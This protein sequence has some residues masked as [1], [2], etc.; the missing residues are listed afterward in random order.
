MLKAEANAVTVLDGIM[1]PRKM[2]Y[3]ISEEDAANA[4]K[5]LEGEDAYV[6]EMY[7]KGRKY[8]LYVHSLGYDGERLLLYHESYFS[9]STYK[10]GGEVF[11]ATASPSGVSLD[12]C[13]RLTI[14]APKVND[15]LCT[16]MKCTLGGVWNGG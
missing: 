5:P 3:A 6:R 1:V 9:T 16:H 13:R 11:K 15:T 4:P 10:Y 14:N 8:F 2:A 7:L 12:E